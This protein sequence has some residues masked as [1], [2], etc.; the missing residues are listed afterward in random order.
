[1]S[2]LAYG[3]FWLG[4]R[5]A[6]WPPARR[7]GP[8][9]VRPRPP[10]IGAARPARLLVAAPARA[11]LVA[12]HGPP[13]LVVATA[14]RATKRQLSRILHSRLVTAITHPIPAG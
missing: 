8:G 7:G 3:L 2:G 6:G 9:R 10:G 5:P 14:P 4:W 12:A 11:G 1:M 13:G